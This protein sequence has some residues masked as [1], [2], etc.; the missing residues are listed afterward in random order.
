MSRFSG[1]SFVTNKL[2]SSMFILQLAG[3][4]IT[5]SDD[6]STINTGLH[7]YTAGVALQQFFIICF[8]VLSVIFRRRLSRECDPERAKS[9]QPLLYTLYLSLALISVS[10]PKT[11]FLLDVSFLT[12]TSSE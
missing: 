7:I 4:A 11:E 8:T 9:V 10:A 3:A 1:C 6:N 12:F 2:F 5:T